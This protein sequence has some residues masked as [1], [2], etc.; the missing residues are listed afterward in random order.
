M[1]YPNLQPDDIVFIRKLYYSPYHESY[2]KS[3]IVEVP[4]KDLP[5]I[6]EQQE[7]NTDLSIFPFIRRQNE[8]LYFVLYVDI[9][10]CDQDRLNTIIRHLNQELEATPF[11]VACTSYRHYVVA[12]LLEPQVP[13]AIHPYLKLKLNHILSRFSC[14]DKNSFNP[15]FPF[16][17]PNSYNYKRNCKTFL[18]AVDYH[19]VALNPY[20]LDPEDIIVAKRGRKLRHLDYETQE[21]F[22]AKIGEVLGWDLSQKRHVGGNK[23]YV[24]IHCVFHPPDK[25]PSAQIFYGDVGIY[26]VDFHNN[27]KYSVQSFLSVFFKT[28]EY[29]A[30]PEETQRELQAIYYEYIKE[31]KNP[32]PKTLRKKGTVEKGEEEEDELQQPAEVDYFLTILQEMTKRVDVILSKKQLHIIARYRNPYNT[33]EDVVISLPLKDFIKV[34]KFLSEFA[35]QVFL[36]PPKLI[37]R[38]FQIPVL[39][40][41]KGIKKSLE[42]AY[43]QYLEWLQEHAKVREKMSLRNIQKDLLTRFLRKLVLSRRTVIKFAFDFNEFMRYIDHLANKKDRIIT[44]IPYAVVEREQAYILVPIDFLPEYLSLNSHHFYGLDL[45]DLIHILT[46]TD[47]PPVYIESISHR[48]FLSIPYSVVIHF[49]GREFAVL[50]DP[51]EK[52]ERRNGKEW[53]K[54]LLTNWN[55]LTEDLLLP[56]W[57]EKELITTDNEKMFLNVSPEI[58][59]LITELLNDIPIKIITADETSFAF[60]VSLLAKGGIEYSIEGQEILVGSIPVNTYTIQDLGSIRA[61]LQITKQEEDENEEE[62]EREEGLDF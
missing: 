33:E 46:T 22:W 37:E 40:Q 51:P 45:T 52:E 47:N 27:T 32:K 36:N 6:I 61:Y 29:R 17:L 34:D 15:N 19:Y 21:K 26:Y 13:F 35:K 23:Y 24:P 11:Y 58:T 2:M 56:V 53:L 38:I 62:E 10:D 41:G 25:N 28:S 18:M 49:A 55:D 14:I 5:K 31:I 12:Y 7:E 43:G 3:E 48:E 59:E 60:I 1:L 30:L 42:M 57:Q 20:K 16:R 8:L 39:Q 50:F 44:Y 9:D 4:H 54:M